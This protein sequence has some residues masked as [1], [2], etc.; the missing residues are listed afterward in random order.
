[1]ASRFRQ[2]MTTRIRRDQPV[3]LNAA[4]KVPQRRAW[5]W[6]AVAGFGLAALGLAAFAWRG[7]DAARAGLLPSVTSPARAATAF[8]VDC[9]ASPEALQRELAA[10]S[11]RFDGT[12]GIAVA[13]AGCDWVAGERL[14]RRFPQQSVSKLWVS[15]AVLDAVDKGRLGLDDPLAIRPVDLT[16][17]NQPLRY[18]VLERGVAIRSVQSLMG[19]ALSHSDNTA[20]DRLLWTVGGPDAVRKVLADKRL[21]DIRFG[22]GERM[23]QSQV[24]GLRWSQDL[25]LG[26]NFEQARARL[27]VEQRQA[28]LEQYI[29]DPLDGA[30][31]KAMARALARLAAGELLS[32]GASAV[33]MG[34]LARTHSG[35]RRLKAGAPSGWKVFHKTGTGQEL[36]RVATGYNDVGVLQAPDGSAYAV[37]VMIAETTVPI[38]QRMEMMQQVSRAIGNFHEAARR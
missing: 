36:R 3:S 16:L 30:T 35:P 2:Q 6:L 38:P 34:I 18:E 17:F 5:G 24:A 33:M 12:V 15:L 29:A 4:F 28:A 8:H 10:I 23:L 1:M 11:A 27:P 25:S 20:N 26:R 32:P 7:T 19:D 37:A 21:G 13:Q 9:R 14:D 22:P 31:P